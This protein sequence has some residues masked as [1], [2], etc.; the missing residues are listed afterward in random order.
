L[1]EGHLPYS[2]SQDDVERRVFVGWALKS[3]QRGFNRKGLRMDNRDI[4]AAWE[5]H[6][7]TKHPN[8]RLMNRWH[9]YDP[10]N[11]PLLFK[12][13]TALDPIPLPLD[14]S[15][16][17]V[18]ALNA[19]A[20]GEIEAGDGQ[21]P[22]VGML[23]RLLWFSAGITKKIT[24]P[25]GEML[26]RAAACTGALYHIEL[27][28]VCADLPGLEAGVYHFAPHDLSLRRLRAGDFRGALVNA[29]G[30]EP[31]VANAPLTIVYTDVFWRNAVKYQA[32]EY[33]HAFWDSG[34]IVSH[35]LAMAAAHKLPARVVAGFVDDIVNRLLDLDTEREATLALL[36]VGYDPNANIGPTPDILPLS[37]QTASISDEE[38]RFPPILTMHQASSLSD[39]TEVV[40]WRGQTPQPSM[41][42]P[43]GQVFP[44]ESPAQDETPI[45]TAIIRRGSTR[46]FSHEAITFRQLSTLLIPATKGV[47][48]DFLQPFGAALNEVYLVVNAVDGLP[49]GAYVFHRGQ[50]ALELLRE[51]DFRERA[52]LLGLQQALPYDASADI[53]LMADLNTTLERYG[54][55]GYRAA[56]LEASIIAGRLYL[57]AYTQGFGASGLTFYDDMV[58]DFFSPHAQDKSTMFLVAVGKKVKG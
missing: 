28:V 48:A 26:F 4:Q 20:A 22:D 46:R 33:R 58:T 1:N 57:A 3:L 29:S 37:L 55:R 43:S 13:Y 52:G 41:P 25:W 36:P 12:L 35:T 47:P 14:P 42:A 53:F 38:I 17:E 23:A 54:N 49:P 18:P 34:T 10:A 2:S 39:S 50:Q 8:G 9:H 6:N 7:G 15:P 44:L 56:Q 51:G 32:R 31:A 30:N 11:H 24:Y 16:S 21:I 27:Y 19:I 40:D 5:Y 45:E